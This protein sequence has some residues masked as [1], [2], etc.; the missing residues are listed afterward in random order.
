MITTI[1]FLLIDSVLIAQDFENILLKNIAGNIEKYKNKEIK[2][3]LRLKKT[4]LIFEKITF[5]DRKNHD[6]VFD[7]SKNKTNRQFR[8]E[9]ENIHNGMEY[10]VLFKVND[11]SG[12]G[13]IIADL[14]SF[15]PYLLNFLPEGKPRI[16]IK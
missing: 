7:I 3:K 5:Y 9:L 6:I 10:L 11:V 16:K 14:I 13:Y 8:K 12:S 1:L 15:R 4:D 2:L